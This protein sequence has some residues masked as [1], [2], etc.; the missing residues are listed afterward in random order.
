ML[1]VNLERSPARSILHQ[2]VGK[3]ISNFVCNVL[4]VCFFAD[5]AV[6]SILGS[7]AIGLF[8]V[9]AIGIVLY[10]CK[11]RKARNLAE[12]VTDIDENHTYGNYDDPDP[13]VEVEDINDYYSSTVYEAD[14]SRTTDNNSQYEN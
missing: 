12:N 14:M 7:V 1:S 13:V 8:L 9:T 3:K 10:I 4:I 2:Q 5:T 6:V 11:R